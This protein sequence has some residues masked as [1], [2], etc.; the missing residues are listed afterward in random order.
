M[1][2]H[3]DRSSL[4]TMG[5]PNEAHTASLKDDSPKIIKKSTL[6]KAKKK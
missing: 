5:R 3:R 2:S 4:G 1:K 6:R